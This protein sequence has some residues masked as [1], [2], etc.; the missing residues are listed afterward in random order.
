LEE[1]S[2]QNVYYS[3]TFN[4]TISY[5]DDVIFSGNNPKK[6][7]E[8]SLI[9]TLGCQSLI[10]PDG[11][12]DDDKYNHI[13][14]Q[15]EYYF[16]LS[17]HAQY[18]DYTLFKSGLFTLKG[19]ERESVLKLNP[20]LKIMRLEN[21]I[22]ERIP[23]NTRNTLKNVIEAIESNGVMGKTPIPLPEMVKFLSSLRQEISFKVLFQNRGLKNVTINPDP[24]NLIGFEPDIKDYFISLRFEIIDNSRSLFFMTLSKYDDNMTKVWEE[25]LV[26]NGFVPKNLVELFETIFEYCNPER[27][28]EYFI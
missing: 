15:Y 12:L 23:Q 10:Y 8:T 22:F 16:V 5:H 3:E 2:Q 13:D 17:K 28:P 24:T 26:E 7:F 14:L 4:L 1:V 11:R 25:E 19:F 6:I 27:N 21:S 9:K 18:N 20:A